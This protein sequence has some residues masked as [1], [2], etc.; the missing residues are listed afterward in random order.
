MAEKARDASSSYFGK[1]KSPATPKK[2]EKKNDFIAKKI[3]ERKEQKLGSS[4]NVTPPGVKMKSVKENKAPGSGGSSTTTNKQA[5]GVMT[6]KPRKKKSPG[7]LGNPFGLRTA[8]RK[9]KEMGPSGVI[10]ALGGVKKH[11][12]KIANYKSGRIV[13]GCGAANMSKI[14][15]TQYK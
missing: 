12:G 5:S 8:A 10:K 11:G 3:K 2:A 14:N 1:A 15:R 6:S 13:R 4:K 9:L 7:A